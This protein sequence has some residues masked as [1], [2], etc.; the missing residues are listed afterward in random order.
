[1][2]KGDETSKLVMN[3]IEALLHHPDRN[4]REAAVDAIV[5][6]HVC[7]RAQMHVNPSCDRDVGVLHLSLY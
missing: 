6:V 2:T 7:V 5:Q 4:V 1:M 3:D